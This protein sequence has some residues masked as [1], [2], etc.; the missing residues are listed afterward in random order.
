MKNR[1]AM[2]SM[3]L[4]FVFV[5]TACAGAAPDAMEKPADEMMEKPTE[6]AMMDKPTEEAMM[7]EPTEEAMMTEE[8]MMTEEAML[9]APDGVQTPSWFGASLRDV[10][11]GESFTI[12]DFK[13]KVVLVETMAV[14][15]PTCYQQQAQIKALYESLGMREDLVIVSLDIDPN[16]DET[17]L[18]GYAEKNS[19]FAWRYAV[20]GSEVAR[21]IGNA[22]G[23]QFL[24]P[25]SAPVLVIDRHGVA[26]ALP[27]GLKS[28]E[29][30][31]K[32]I[33]PYLDGTM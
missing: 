22:H 6:E 20:A 26:H 2:L 12:D 23:D 4:L 24:N 10:R 11:S 27:F 19:E 1:T 5:L 14:W 18:T 7:D 8:P 25:P 3:I 29:D 9:E 33:Q 28:A 17:V 31:M 13:G 15:C 30:L 21:A 32:A 16:E